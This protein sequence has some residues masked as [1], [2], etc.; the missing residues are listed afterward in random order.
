V[1]AVST[2]KPH[3]KSAEYALNQSRAVQ[4]WG[5]IFTHVYLIGDPEPDL[6]YD[7]VTFIEGN[8]YPTIKMMVLMLSTYEE[9]GAW[10]NCDIIVLPKIHEAMQQMEVRGYRAATSQRFEYDPVSFDLSKAKIPHHDFGLDIFITTGDI[11]RDMF[12]K[13]NPDLRTC[14]LIYDSWMT[15]YLWH[16]LGHGYRN[17]TDYRCVFHPKHGGREAPYMNSP[18]WVQDEYGKDARIPPPLEHPAP[19]RYKSLING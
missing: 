9:W 11:W 7:Y 15:G 12:T 8:D 16:T 2:F 6:R 3:A 13:I 5:D 10:I 17:F 14:G 18:Q 19:K 4:S 1:I